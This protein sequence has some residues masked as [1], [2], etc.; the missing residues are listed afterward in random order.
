[1]PCGPKTHIRQ[2]AG[3][4]GTTGPD[5]T[6]GKRR[7]TGEKRARPPENEQSGSGHPEPL[8]FLSRRNRPAGIPSHVRGYTK[9][10][11]T[12]SARSRRPRTSTAISVPAFANS[13]FT[14]PMPKPTFM[15]GDIV[16]EVTW[17]ISAPSGAV[18]L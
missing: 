11:F 2:Y 14:Y 4:K 8:C 7:K 10:S 1:M 15:Q 16:P 12:T 17:P 5:N 3:P 13:G 6:A 18:S 9:G